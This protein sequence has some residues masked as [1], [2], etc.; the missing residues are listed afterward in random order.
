MSICQ[1]CGTE[2]EQSNKYR[3]S[4]TCSKA[5]RY[6]LS[7][8]SNKQAQGA[9]YLDRECPVCGKSFDGKTAH[10]SRIC[11]N[12][13]RSGD[14]HPAVQAAQEARSSPCKVCGEPTQHTQRDTCPDHRRGWQKRELATCPC[15]Q[16]AENIR[17]KYCCVEHRKKWGRKPA[18]KMVEHVCQTCGD[19]FERPH[20][21]PTK[22]M[23]CSIECS[24]R[25]HSRKRARHYQFGDLNLNSSFELRFVACLERLKVKWSPWPDDRPF[26]YSV[27]GVEHTYTP[28]F[29]VGG[30]AVETKGWDHPDSTQPVGRHAWDFPEPLCL[31]NRERLN[32]CEH[33]F[34]QRTLV[35]YLTIDCSV[36]LH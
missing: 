16:P 8:R 11:S 13:A 27:N 20:F 9:Q 21:Y 31:V 19:T 2:F 28:D 6:V 15:G 1:N 4:K 33:I 5:C 24:N 36:P 18:V 12:R 17:S 23:F 30:L 29:L 26:V 7:G 14:Q 10:C 32:E 25:Q 22:G 34:N 3:E 35:D